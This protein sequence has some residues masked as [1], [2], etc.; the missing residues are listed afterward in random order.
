MSS[1]FAPLSKAIL[2]CAP[3]A[4]KIS[5]RLGSAPVKLAED[6]ETVGRGLGP[7]KDCVEACVNTCSQSWL[8]QLPTIMSAARMA[9]AVRGFVI[10]HPINAAGIWAF[11]NQQP[12]RVK[13]IC[14]G[15]V[16][17]SAKKTPKANPRAI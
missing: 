13:P 8:A 1:D 15:K 7:E 2:V 6:P 12:R 10:Q 14:R 16:G 17:E 3:G 11:R 9:G 5:L 4:V